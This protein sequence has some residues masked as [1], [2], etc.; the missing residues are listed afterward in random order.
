MVELT[1]GYPIDTDVEVYSPVKL[2]IQYLAFDSEEK[3]P[4]EIYFQYFEKISQSLLSTTECI[5]KVYIF[6]KRLSPYRFTVG[7]L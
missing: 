7:L 2:S 6:P 5:V 3:L 4:S 1:Q